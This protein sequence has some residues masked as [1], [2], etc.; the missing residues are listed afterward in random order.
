M[1]A[2][3]T[4]VIV[5]LPLAGTVPPVRLIWFVTVTAKAVPPQVFVSCGRTPLLKPGLL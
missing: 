2:V 1:S 5:Q 4:A 3:T